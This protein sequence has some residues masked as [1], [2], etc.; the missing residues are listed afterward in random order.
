MTKIYPAFKYG[1]FFRVLLFVFLASNASAACTDDGAGNIIFDNTA[2]ETITDSFTADT[3]TKIGTGEVILTGSSAIANNVDLQEGT[4][5][6]LPPLDEKGLTGE[7][8]W[9]YEN[10]QPSKKFGNLSLGEIFSPKK[11]LL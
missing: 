3:L 7:A 8:S 11:L 10:N 1:C 2:T 4:L 6:I 9:N 5:S